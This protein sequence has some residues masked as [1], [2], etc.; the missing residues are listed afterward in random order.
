MDSA[1]PRRYL[2]PEG[3]PGKL[4]TALLRAAASGRPLAMSGG[5][6]LWDPVHVGD[7]VASIMGLLSRSPDERG[8]HWQLT[9]DSPLPIRQYVDQ[10]SGVL[11]VEFPVIW[12][13][14]PDRGREDVQPWLVAQRPPGWRPRA[15]FVEE[16][17]RIWGEEFDPKSSRRRE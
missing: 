12:G 6:Q 5:N 17:R 4:L 15:D 7:V 8:H 9:S 14:R 10:L 3:R 1:R 13:A 16:I 11:G 2:R